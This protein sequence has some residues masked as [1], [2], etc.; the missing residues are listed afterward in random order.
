MTH[1]KAHETEESGERGGRVKNGRFC[2]RNSGA[3]SPGVLVTK[4]DSRTI[5]RRGG[6]QRTQVT[7]RPSTL[8]RA[9]NGAKRAG[10]FAPREVFRI[11]P[12][13]EIGRM[14]HTSSVT[15]GTILAMSV[16]GSAQDPPF[17][18]R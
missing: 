13:T 16:P 2:A 14:G 15:S 17:P 18:F 12:F 10:C 4:S 7:A 5:V 3:P 1:R 11:P 8:P 6:D 9:V